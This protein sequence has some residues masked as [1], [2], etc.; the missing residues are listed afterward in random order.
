MA[1]NRRRRRHAHA[2]LSIV[3]KTVGAAFVVVVSLALVYLWMGHKCTA[4]SAEIKRLEDRCGELDNE[5]VR[6][7]TQWNAM[8]T[9]E[10]LDGLL[11]R[12]GLQMVYPN[13]GQVVR[14]NAAGRTT[15]ASL[16][17]QGPATAP[18]G[19][20]QVAGRAQR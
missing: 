9:A 14:M 18:R 12:H 8:K 17:A 4:Y 11:L 10:K 13:A 1:R 16:V 5:K 2:L 15:G 7:E 3:P 6:E 19:A 20:T